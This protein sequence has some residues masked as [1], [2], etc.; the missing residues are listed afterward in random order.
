MNLCCGWSPHNCHSFE[1][2]FYDA[3]RSAKFRMQLQGLRSL[4][5]TMRIFDSL[6]MAITLPRFMVNLASAIESLYCLAVS[7]VYV[8][9]TLIKTTGMHHT[10]SGNLCRSMY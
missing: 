9:V 5:L 4:C 3:C 6:P 2:I 10:E 8:D 1:A 7:P